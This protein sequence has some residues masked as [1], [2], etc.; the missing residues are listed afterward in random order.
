MCAFSPTKLVPAKLLLQIDFALHGFKAY[1]ELYKLSGKVSTLHEKIEAELR[2][3]EEGLYE[4]RITPAAAVAML[5]NAIIMLNKSL[6]SHY[7]LYDLQEHPIL[8]CITT[9]QIFL[10]TKIQDLTG[11]AHSAPLQVELGGLLF[12]LEGLR[13]NLHLHILSEEEALKPLIDV[14]NSANA[15]IAPSYPL[16][17]PKILL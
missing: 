17:N 9:F 13:D 5:N 14:I 12:E 11:V 10:T 3:L 16:P 2:T 7:P 15:L 8:Q 6:E 4:S 1:V